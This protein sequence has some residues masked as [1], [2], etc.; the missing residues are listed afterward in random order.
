MPR[1]WAWWLVV[2][3]AWTLLACVFAVSSS[4]T[5]MLAY[6]PPQWRQT[7]G[8]AFT[9]WYV[10]AAMTP[11]V[12]WLARR[13]MLRRGGWVLRAMVLAAIGLPV[14]V[15][16]VTLTRALRGLAGPDEYFLISNLTTHYLIYWGII[17]IVH[18]VENYRAGRERELRAAQLEARLAEARMQLLKMQLHPHFLFNTLNAI[19]ELVHEDPHN[20]EKM[21][22]GLS[23]LLRE[24]LEAGMI[25]AVP[26]A[27]ELDLLDRYTAIQRTR[28]GD[29]LDVR[30]SIEDPAARDALVPILILQPLVENAI[31]H[32][33]AERARAGRIDVRARRHG[34]RLVLEVEDDGSGLP[35]GAAREGVGVGNTKARLAEMYGRNQEFELI[36]SKS[37]TV[38]RVSI[39][40]QTDHNPAGEV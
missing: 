26:L 35:Q 9:E 25:D 14:A 23:H 28:F 6:R 33:I 29:R 39:P 20:A 27:R 13:L 36:G 8:M 2:L 7:F 4:L 1:R 3:A 12:V 32:G 22:G 30:V 21:I 40:W 15:I 34:Q 16:K 37:G 31:R 19:S 17:G 5:Y 11:L 18:A 38:A 24:T 10:W